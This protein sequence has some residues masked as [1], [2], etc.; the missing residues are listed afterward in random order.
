MHDQRDLD[1][2]IDGSD[3]SVQEGKGSEGLERE[4]ILK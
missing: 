4:M 3:K 1:Y 2:K